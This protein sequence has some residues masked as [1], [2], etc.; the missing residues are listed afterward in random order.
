M[1]CRIGFGRWERRFGWERR[2][3]EVTRRRWKQR[4]KDNAEGA[5]NRGVGKEKSRKDSEQRSPRSK[6]KDGDLGPHH[7]TFAQTWASGTIGYSCGLA[8]EIECAGD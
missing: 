3:D 1:T 2:R 7:A 8:I 6:H 5:E 4:R